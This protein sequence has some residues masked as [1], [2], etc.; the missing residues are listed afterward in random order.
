MAIPQCTP[1]HYYFHVFYSCNFDPQQVQKPEFTYWWHHQRTPR[2]LCPISRGA[3]FADTGLWHFVPTRLSSTESYSWYAVMI[4]HPICM[5]YNWSKL[6]RRT[7]DFISGGSKIII[8]A[9]PQNILPKNCLVIW[10][11]ILWYYSLLGF[12]VTPMFTTHTIN[13]LTSA[14]KKLVATFQILI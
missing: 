4:K 8:I 12:V 6:C 9:L 13:A 7:T 11:V 14:N 10:C 3:Y 2:I 5:L 1:I